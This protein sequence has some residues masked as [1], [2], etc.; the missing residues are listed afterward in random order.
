MKIDKLKFTKWLKYLFDV[1]L[2]EVEMERADV[3]SKPCLS[4]DLQKLTLMELTACRH[5][6]RSRRVG[7]SGSY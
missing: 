2:G 3:E 7:D 5:E 6:G 4:R 1:G